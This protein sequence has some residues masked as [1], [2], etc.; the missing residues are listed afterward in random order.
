[1]FCNN[2]PAGKSGKILRKFNK[3]NFSALPQG[4]FRHFRLYPQFRGNA[5]KSPFLIFLASAARRKKISGNCLMCLKDNCQGFQK[6]P[7]EIMPGVS[8]PIF[9]MPKLKS[10]GVAPTSPTYEGPMPGLKGPFSY[11]R[12]P[13]SDLGLIPDLRGPL[14][15]LR[16]LIPNLK[17]PIPDL[18]GHVLPLLTGPIPGQRGPFYYNRP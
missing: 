18:A 16:R 4:F 6:T 13:N 14:P 12:G 1:M 9:F 15:D 7:L 10:F 5:E 3:I 2:V 8:L 11:L 17:G